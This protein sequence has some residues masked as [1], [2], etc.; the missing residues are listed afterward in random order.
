MDLAKLCGQYRTAPASERQGNTLV[1]QSDKGRRGM[2]KPSIL[3]I[4]ALI[5]SGIT[6]TS[7]AAR[8][9]KIQ[10]P[11]DAFVCV[12][13][14]YDGCL[15][16]IQAESLHRFVSLAYK[17][18]SYASIR[19]QDKA[20]TETKTADGKYSCHSGV[21]P[22]SPKMNLT[23]VVSIVF[24][25]PLLVSQINEQQLR[26]DKA[27]DSCLRYIQ[28]YDYQVSLVKQQDAIAVL[29]RLR[30]KIVAEMSADRADHEKYQ[31]TYSVG[32]RA[33]ATDEVAASGLAAGTTISQAAR[34]LEDAIY[35]LSET[36]RDN[37][38]HQVLDIDFAR[39]FAD[40]QLLTDSQLRELGRE[41]FVLDRAAPKYSGR[42]HMR[43]YDDG[44]WVQKGTVVAV[45]GGLF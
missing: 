22:Y 11:F 39:S 31:G 10:S 24:V 1:G 42:I 4:S 28:A 18:P 5:A 12:K 13:S 35:G 29:D 9:I 34:Q 40:A 16:R 36:V 38:K 30:A 44:S 19:T 32:Q 25:S 45:S 23:G 3:V 6:P 20:D 43:G 8:Q 15:K 37:S 33:L 2:A 21:I 27:R 17:Q 26:I 14:S 7:T 41:L